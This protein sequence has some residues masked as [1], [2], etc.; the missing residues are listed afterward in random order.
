MDTP[1]VLS[2]TCQALHTKYLLASKTVQVLSVLSFPRTKETDK[3]YELHW[4]TANA[5]GEQLE[6]QRDGVVWLGEAKA[7]CKY[8]LLLF[9]IVVVGLLQGKQN[10]IL[11]RGTQ[12]KHQHGCLSLQHWT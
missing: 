10:Q 5:A 4:K 8:C 9:E 3:L 1:Q 2:H 11:L 12:G 6:A 7:G